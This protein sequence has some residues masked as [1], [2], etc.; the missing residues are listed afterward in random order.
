[1]D[2]HGK[3]PSEGKRAFGQGGGCEVRT[4]DFR[5]LSGVAIPEEEFLLE[6]ADSRDFS[7]RSCWL[8]RDTDG[9][10][11]HSFISSSSLETQQVKSREKQVGCMVVATLFLG[12]CHEPWSCPMDMSD[13]DVAL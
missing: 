10:K 9:L 2:A 4:D 12:P 5:D 1:M 6:S 13:D 3:G 11:V 8:L 7:S